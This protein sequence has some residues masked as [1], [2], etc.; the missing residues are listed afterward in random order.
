MASEEEERKVNVVEKERF[1]RKMKEK[2]S[3]PLL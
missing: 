3:Y 2:N 1:E